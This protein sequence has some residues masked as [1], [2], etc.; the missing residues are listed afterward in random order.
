[1]RSLFLQRMRMGKDAA[2]VLE[3]QARDC[4][5]SDPRRRMVRDDPDRS[6]LL[7]ADC[8]ARCAWA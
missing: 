4:Q 8:C 2:A 1:M 6:T 3:R 5:L 7:R